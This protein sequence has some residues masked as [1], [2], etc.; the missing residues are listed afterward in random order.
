MYSR[1]IRA[2]ALLNEELFDLDLE[3]EVDLDLDLD[4]DALLLLLLLFETDSD[5][6]F[7]RLL[8]LLKLLLL[9][10]DLEVVRDLASEVWREREEDLE[11]A[12]RAWLLLWLLRNRESDNDFD[13][14][15]DTDLDL[16]R[17]R[18]LDLLALVDRL[19]F[20]TTKASASSTTASM[21]STK[22]PRAWLRG[23][24]ASWPLGWCRAETTLDRRRVVERKAA[25]VGRSIVG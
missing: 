3:R 18:D 4:S 19:R 24:R 8:L 7:E 12:M 15:L 5:F 16:L 13:L 25:E 22:V 17:L 1:A 9:L 6:D 20:R 2:F 23:A 11:A 21:L 10:S 14:D